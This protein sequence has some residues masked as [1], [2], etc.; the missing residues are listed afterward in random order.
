MNEGNTRI[1]KDFVD[2]EELENLVNLRETIL[3]P[4]YLIGPS[5]VSLVEGFH[6]ELL[7]DDEKQEQIMEVLN[8]TSNKPIADKDSVPVAAFPHYASIFHPNKVCIS[9]DALEPEP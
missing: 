1:D 3:P 2:D 8:L 4:S 9:I 5:T 7:L 6:S